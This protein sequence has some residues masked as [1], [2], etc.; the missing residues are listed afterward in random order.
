MRCPKCQF[1]NR[2]EA[3]FCKECGTKLE[4]ACPECGAKF[5]S[6]GKFCDEC[7]HDFSK[8]TK[9]STVNDP[10]FESHP[11][12]HIAANNLMRHSP[13]DG[14]RKHVTVL[15][16]DLTGYTAMSEKLDPEDVKGIT[17]RIFGAIST[18][19]DQPDL[20]R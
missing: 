9:V 20:F 12:E 15:F 4:L 13:I 8:R 7:G 14:E 10:A 16:S 17:S 19:Y 1:D 6:P 3:K 5:S 18:T 2:A 11:P